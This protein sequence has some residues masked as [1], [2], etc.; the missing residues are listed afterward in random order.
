MKKI[1]ILTVVL[2]MIGFITNAQN[3]KVV[4]AYNYWG[5]GK[6][7]KA[8]ECIDVATVHEQTMNDAKT[9]LYRGNIYYNIYISQITAYKNL[10]SNALNVATEA[11]SKCIDLDK[12]NSYKEDAI[13]GINN[14][15]DLLIGKAV[16]L[17][18]KKDYAN[19][20]S[21]AEKNTDLLKKIGEFDYYGIYVAGKCYELS[22]ADT[23][24]KNINKYDKAEQLYT[25]LLDN[26]FYKKMDT[27]NSVQIYNALAEI[28]LF[29]KQA[30]KALTI[31]QTAR[32]IYP[33][34]FSLLLEEANIYLAKDNRDE[35][36]KIIDLAIE[37]QPS[38]AF[39]RY[40]I[41][42]KY[43]HDLDK[44]TYSKDSSTFL[45]FFKLAETNLLMAIQLKPDFY[46]AIYNLGALYLN[47]GL[48]VKLDANNIDVNDIVKFN[49]EIEKSQ[50]LFKKSI[51]QF[52]KYYLAFPNDKE[53][54]RN[55]KSLY[56]NT[57]QQN[58]PKCQ[59]IINKLK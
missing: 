15:S 48:R 54:M 28:L 1:A 20:I 36:D 13:I 30:D 39:L 35:A 31:I 49:Q 3:P 38:N 2:I 27:A 55:L 14:C 46:D 26:N 23:A 51:E 18:D 34:E 16:K 11:Y 19:A 25:S 57:N 10:D 9:W 41:G 40:Y 52:E 5:K 21:I 33:D 56:I 17:F 42:S 53:I 47:E 22:V 43:F 6:L 24:N 12:K 37:K 58:S 45:H 4:S 59:E 50:N 8:K 32:K 29:K 7:D 44:I